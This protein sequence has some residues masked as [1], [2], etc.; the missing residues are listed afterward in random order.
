MHVNTI[1][2]GRLGNGRLATLRGT[3]AAMNGGRQAPA[4]RPSSVHFGDISMN[5][6][7]T[8]W[9]CWPDS[10]LDDADASDTDSI[11]SDM[12]VSFF[13][14]SISDSFR[15]RT[16]DGSA[17]P[18]TSRKRVR[19]SRRVSSASSTATSSTDPF[20]SSHSS[21]ANAVQS[22]SSAS[23]SSHANAG[24]SP[25]VILVITRIFVLNP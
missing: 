6:L 18:S 1:F 7:A 2:I 15:K 19:P 22:P 8:N 11:I 12:T 23:T 13:Q 16:R 25:V 10:W 21:H 14:L 5:Q 3:S 24:Q 4:A 20:G 17:S 9:R